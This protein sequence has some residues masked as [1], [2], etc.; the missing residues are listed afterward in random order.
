MSSAILPA[1][2]GFF[3][4]LASAGS[5][6][7][8]ARELGI[9]TPAVSK[10]LALMESRAGVLLVN[11]STR[12][13]SLTPEGEL[14]L[15]HARR[16]LGEIDGMEELLGVSRATPRGLLRVNATLGFGRSHVAPLIS[17]FV[18]KHPAAEVQ[19]QLS[20]NPP[21]PSEDLFDVC[22]RFGAPPDIRVVAR[23]IA[24][25]RRLLCAS[26]AYLAARGMPKVPNDLARH[27]CIGIRQGEEAY[28]VWRLTSGRGRHARTESVRTRG[29]L[30][31]NDGEIAVN[32]A[33]EGHGIL[34]RA[35]WDINRYLRSGRLVQVLPQYFTPDAD[36][37][38]VYPQR[39]QLAA[40]V[41]AFVDFLALSF[42]QQAASGK[43]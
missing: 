23:H 24:S 34:M 21:A 1:D 26:P 8:A 15:E 12:R 30:A 27:N 5:L 14:Y 13:M 39:H 41:R 7:A 32:W 28:G 4:T 2:L 35:E 16:I 6:S 40:R 42:T 31:T 37:Y 20:V 3:S 43:A 9:T 19:L 25:N 36:I 22:V 17:R 29:N 11:R 18:R 33:L 10:H 38:A